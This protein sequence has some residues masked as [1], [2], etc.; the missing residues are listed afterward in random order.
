MVIPPAIA[1]WIPAILVTHW[2]QEDLKG[3]H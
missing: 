3:L 1:G 2:M